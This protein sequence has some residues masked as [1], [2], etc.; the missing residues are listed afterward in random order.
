MCKIIDIIP[1]NYKK[2]ADFICEIY[3]YDIH[4]T[5]LLFSVQCG[6]A[7]AAP[8]HITRKDSRKAFVSYSHKDKEQVVD[9]LL[10]MQSVAP[11]L[12]FWI[13]SQSLEAGQPWRTEIRTAIRHA[14]V[15]LLFWSRHSKASP[16]VEKEWRYALELRRKRKYRIGAGFITPVPLEDP[17]ICPPPE[18][19]N[20]LHFGDPVFDSNFNHIEDL[21]ILQNKKRYKNIRLL[22]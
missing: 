19:L 8:V 18:E 20:S 16:E 15:F 6:Q 10:A 14:D 2:S 9:R 21:N 17:S 4:V 13:D 7:S 1:I 12:R 5:R 22:N 3:F 11:K